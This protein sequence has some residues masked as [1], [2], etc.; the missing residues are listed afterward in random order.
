MLSHGFTVVM[1]RESLLVPGVFESVARKLR[2][3]RSHPAVRQLL[4]DADAALGAPASTLLDKKH[5]PPSGDKRDYFSLSVYFWP[6]PSKPEGLPYI[7]RDGAVNPETDQYDRPAL[8]AMC[9]R[10]DVLAFAYTITGEER[11]AEKAAQLLRTWFLDDRTSM[12]PNMLFAQHIPGKDVVLPWKDF[13]ARFVPGTDG[14]EGIFVSFGGVIESICLVPLTDAVRLLQGSSAWTA[15]DDH[16]LRQWFSD[17]ADWLLTHQ[18]GR[19]EASCRNNH[20][21]WY[22]AQVACYLDFAQRSEAIARRIPPVLS[23]RLKLQIDPDGSQPEELVRAISMSYCAFTI[24]SLVNLSICAAR[25]GIDTWAVQSDDGRSIRLAVE[26]MTPFL[27]GD[28][29]WTRRQIKPFDAGVML[30]PLQACAQCF[31][32]GPWS[33]T[34]EHLRTQVPREHRFRVLYDLL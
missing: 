25:M 29:P 16:K 10:V 13:P 3:D 7:P 4:A 6:D 30:G 34:L 17:Y 21:S 5:L 33:R 28:K 8:A 32:D 18:H 12:K 19:D 14:R 20:G 15:S 24:A 31:P 27:R 2:G 9:D 11:Y 22:W 26:W 23:E 1:R